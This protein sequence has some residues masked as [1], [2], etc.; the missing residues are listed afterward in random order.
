MIKIFTKKSYINGKGLF[1]TEDVK[2]GQTITYIDGPKIVVRKFTD[3]INFGSHNWIGYSKCTWIDTKNSQFRFINHSCEPNVAIKG[4]RHVYALID[5]PAEH[6]ITMD[7]SLTEPGPDWSLKC[8]CKTKK[9][10]GIVTPITELE[11]HIYRDKKEIISKTFNKIYLLSKKGK[12]H[13]V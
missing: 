10:R 4:K 13:K 6:E 7:Y 9:C 8:N 11:P 2:K 1:I 5:I 3:D 12:S